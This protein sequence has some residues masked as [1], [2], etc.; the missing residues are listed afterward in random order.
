MILSSCCC[1]LSSHSNHLG[2]LR[3]QIS[4]KHRFGPSSAQYLC[5]GQR[6]Q[7]ITTDKIVQIPVS[8]GKPM[9]EHRDHNSHLM[10][11]KVQ[12][13][14]LYQQHSEGIV[15]TMWT[16]AR[17]LRSINTLGLFISEDIPKIWSGIQIRMVRG[18]GYMQHFPALELFSTKIMSS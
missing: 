10:S 13:L 4:I 16:G 14:D 6:I 3:R 17:R 5:Q 18:K 12:R 11:M 7:Y 8:V 15:E 2:H 9:R 1:L